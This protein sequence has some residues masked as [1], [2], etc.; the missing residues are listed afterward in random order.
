[1]AKND[2]LKKVKDRLVYSSDKGWHLPKVE[3]VSL[4][5]NTGKN[6]YFKGTTR[7]EIDCPNARVFK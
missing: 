4:A 2:M 3:T 7:Q 5:A 1:M 6:V